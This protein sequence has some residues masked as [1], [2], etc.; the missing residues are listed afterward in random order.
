MILQWESNEL[1]FCEARL[2]FED[3][4]KIDIYSVINNHN[5]NKTLRDRLS[6]K[7]Y[8]HL[9]DEVTEKY[10]HYLDVHMGSF[11]ELLKKQGNG[12][13]KEFLNDYGDSVYR[14]FYLDAPLVA[15]NK[16]LYLFVMNA[17][18]IKYIGSCIKKSNFEKRIR[19]GYGNVSPRNCFLDG[20]STNCRIN[21]L[22]NKNIDKVKL[23]T[24]SMKR[25]SEIIAA[26]DYLIKRYKPA[27]NI[28]GK[29]ENTQSKKDDYIVSYIGR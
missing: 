1:R 22:I 6:K 27:W 24:L 20:Q 8:R 28:R 18:E 29:R 17:Q 25:D 14:S 23:F 3:K 2:R 26:E 12:F 13:Y 19:Q 9:T 11:L 15:R 21:S 10:I 7:K 16:G 5:V 4:T